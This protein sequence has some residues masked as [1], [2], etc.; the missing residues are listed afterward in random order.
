MAGSKSS[1]NAPS[2]LLGVIWLHS[3]GVRM[4]RAYSVVPGTV[5]SPSA[6]FPMFMFDREMFWGHSDQHF[7]SGQVLGCNKE[8][9]QLH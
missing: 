3:V 8:V 6:G 7:L 2:I 1:K 9:S 5:T 4:E